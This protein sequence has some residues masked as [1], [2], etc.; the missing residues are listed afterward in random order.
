MSDHSFSRDR[1]QPALLDRL[2]D[3]APQDQ[4]EAT[5]ARAISRSRLREIVLRDLGWL[6]NATAP[7]SSGLVEEDISGQGDSPARHSVL[8]YGMP[9]LSGQ[10]VSRLE[11]YDLE[12]ALRQAIVDFEPRILPTTLVVTG[13]QPVDEL[14]HHNLL[15]FDISGEIWSQP[16]PLE[17]LLRTDLDLETGMVMVHDAKTSASAMRSPGAS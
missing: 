2:I 6:L 11:L 13:R 4:R 5:E 17:L 12:Q 3:E 15:Q 16:Y 7:L 1:L 10:L 14:G 9:C 8:N